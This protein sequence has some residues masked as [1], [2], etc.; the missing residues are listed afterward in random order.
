MPPR[1]QSHLRGLPLTLASAAESL[2][3]KVKRLRPERI[4][5]GSTPNVESRVGT[6][7]GVASSSAGVQANSTEGI[8][9]M[10]RDR[11]ARSLTAMFTRGFTGVPMHPV[12]PSTLVHIAPVP[13]SAANAV[14]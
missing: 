9:D 2:E 4:S 11:R 10:V 12:T 7:S 14:E 3:A 13:L 5:D 8:D 1:R 6:P